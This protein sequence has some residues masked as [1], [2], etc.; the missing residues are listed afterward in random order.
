MSNVQCVWPRKQGVWTLIGWH[1]TE[2]E[3]CLDEFV[4]VEIMHSYAFQIVTMTIICRSHTLKS[5]QTAK[6][7]NKQIIKQTDKQTN[8]HTNK[9][10]ATNLPWLRDA[11]WVN[12]IVGLDYSSNF[13]VRNIAWSKK[14]RFGKINETVYKTSGH[15]RD[16]SHSPFSFCLYADERRTVLPIESLICD[17]GGVWCYIAPLAQ[18]YVMLLSAIWMCILLIKSS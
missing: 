5:K 15:L 16:V 14:E 2:W 11:E 3:E 8:K 6:H 7:A 10:T 17:S 18:Q 13:I 4:E 12:K 1:V 9:W